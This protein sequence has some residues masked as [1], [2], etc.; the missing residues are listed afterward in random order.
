M[1]F[2]FGNVRTVLLMKGLAFKIARVRPIRLIRWM[3]GFEPD[4][5]KYFVGKR[6]RFL[7]VLGSTLFGGMLSN[8]REYFYSRSHPDDVRIKPISKMFLF[9]L[10]TI[11]PRGKEATCTDVPEE[12]KYLLPHEYESKY[13]K[14]Y[15]MFEGLALLIDY[16]SRSTIKVL[17]ST[18]SHRLKGRFFISKKNQPRTLLVMSQPRSILLV[19]KTPLQSFGFIWQ[20]FL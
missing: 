4:Y 10:V 6:Y 16:G 18:Y 13:A 20:T 12:A 15:A 3:F 14:Q 7:W 19:C 17:K 9:G 1:V 2:R 5:D 11:Q 8:R